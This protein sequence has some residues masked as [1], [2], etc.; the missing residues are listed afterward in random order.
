[1]RK[2][3]LIL[4]LFWLVQPAWAVTPAEAATLALRD[5][6]K[7]PP[8][9]QQNS[10]YLWD[11]WVNADD[12]EWA[13]RFYSVITFHVNSISREAELKAPIRINPGVWR[14]DLRDYGW[15]KDVYNKL[16]DLDPYFHAKIQNIVTP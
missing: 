9:A 1:M 11:F 16:A 15:K 8:D 3:L 4:T 12:K 13:Q 2:H 7:L 6:K 14:I 5:V 10:V